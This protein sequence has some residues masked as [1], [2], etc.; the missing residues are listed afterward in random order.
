MTGGVAR[1]STCMQTSACV[2]YSCSCAE[3]MPSPI[4]CGALCCRWIGSTIAALN[5]PPASAST[6]DPGANYLIML[7]YS[8]YFMFDTYRK[9]HH[10]Y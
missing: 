4:P 7:H 5:P 9:K 8:E 6:Q 1:N 3:G 2:N 10:S